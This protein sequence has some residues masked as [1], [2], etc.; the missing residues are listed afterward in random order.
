M[1]AFGL[2]LG[3]VGS[4]PMT[5]NP[6]FTFGLPELL[7][8]L[9]FL[10]VTIGLFAI[11]EVLLTVRGSL[12]REVAKTSIAGLWPTRADWRACRWTFPCASFLGFFVGSCRASPGNG[13]DWPAAS[14]S[15]TGSIPTRPESLASMRS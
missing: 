3:V 12:S 2:L 15:R 7:D 4:D 14:S 11:A 9:E 8:G 10:P 5:G 6:R 1:G 13:T